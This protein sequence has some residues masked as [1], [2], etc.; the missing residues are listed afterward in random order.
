[1]HPLPM[2]PRIG[3]LDQLTVRTNRRVDLGFR[4]GPEQR[5]QFGTAFTAE[6]ELPGVGAVPG[7]PEVEEPPIGVEFSFGRL[8]SGSIASTTCSASRFNSFGPNWEANRV[9]SS[10]PAARSAGSNPGRST[11]ASAAR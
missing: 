9:S 8:P 1:M 11:R 3:L 6:P 10:S 7:L 5:G 4:Y 2:M